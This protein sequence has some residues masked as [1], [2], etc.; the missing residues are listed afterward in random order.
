MSPTCSIFGRQV[1]TSSYQCASCARIRMWPQAWLYKVIARKVCD[2]NARLDEANTRCSR[3]TCISNP[4]LLSSSQT[5]KTR[6]SS[7]WS[8]HSGFWLQAQFQSLFELISRDAHLLQH[9]M[10]WL[11]TI[12]QC[13]G[14]FG[15]RC[16]ILQPQLSRPI[17]GLHSTS[18]CSS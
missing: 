1:G 13:V 10:S 3:G 18:S 9:A 2:Q 11:D 4:Q 6:L 15:L 16:F 17:L 8:N 7:T 5:L 14:R 12:P